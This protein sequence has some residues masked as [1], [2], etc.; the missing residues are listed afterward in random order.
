VHQ[1]AD[2][3]VGHEQASELLL[4]H[5]RRLAAQYNLSAT[6]MGLELVQSGLPGKRLARCADASPVSSP[7]PRKLLV[8]FSLKQ[9]AQRVSSKAVCALWAGSRFHVP[10]PTPGCG[11][12]PQSQ[13]S[14]GRLYLV[15][16]SIRPDAKHPTRNFIDD[17]FDGQQGGSM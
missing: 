15:A 6:Q 7:S 13:Y 16:E 14:P 12:I 10:L 9:L 8:R 4:H 11:G 5:F 1:A 17:L 2:G 3:I